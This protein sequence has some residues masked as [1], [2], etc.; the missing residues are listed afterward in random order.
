MPRKSKAD[1]LE[2]R[3]IE[4]LERKC[5]DPAVPAYVQHRCVATLATLLRRR[6]KRLD[7]KAASAERRRAFKAEADRIAR[8]AA[9]PHLPSNGREPPPDWKP[10]QVQPFVI[11]AGINAD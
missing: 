4:D 3:L 5:F 10:T 9:N 1:I 6:D 7:V 8:F 11:P 2:N